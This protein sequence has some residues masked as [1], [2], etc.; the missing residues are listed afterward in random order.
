MNKFIFAAITIYFSIGI[1]QLIIGQQTT[2]KLDGV[3]KSNLPASFD[4]QNYNPEDFYYDRFGNKDLISNIKINRRADRTAINRSG[5]AV[6]AGYFELIYDETNTGFNE[7][8]TIGAK[9]RAVLE[10]VL[11]DIS[12]LLSPPPVSDPCTGALSNVILLIN[13]NTTFDQGTL[14]AA[15]SFYYDN[16][17]NSSIIDGEVWTRL[18]HGGM[19]YNGFADGKINI[20]FDI[21]YYLELD[22]NQNPINILQFDL[23]SV[24]LHEVLHA[25]GFNSSIDENGESLFDYRDLFSRFDQL[26]THNGNPVLS[27]WSGLK[28]FDL[29][30]NLDQYSVADGCQS[31]RSVPSSCNYKTTHHPIYSPNIYVEGS[32]LSHFDAAC[33]DGDGNYRDY[34]MSPSLDPGVIRRFPDIEEVY[35]LNEIGY[36]TTGIYGENSSLASNYKNYNIGET[37]TAIGGTD[38]GYECSVEYIVRTCDSHSILIPALENDLNNPDGYLEIDPSYFG[39]HVVT[40]NIIEF[41]PANDVYRSINLNYVP[42][43]GCMAGSPTKIKIMLA[44]CID[45]TCDLINEN[46]SLCA[47]NCNG[48]LENY[49]FG[50]IHGAESE[51]NDCN[52]YKFYRDIVQYSVPHWTKLYSSCDIVK[53]NVTGNSSIYAA[54]GEYPAY[55]FDF[56]AG[57]LY[58]FKFDITP[59]C[60]TGLNYTPHTSKIKIVLYNE[61]GDGSYPQNF[62]FGSNSFQ[63]IEQYMD[64][65]SHQDVL[66]V[67]SNIG[68]S[69]LTVDSIST[70]LS[71][72]NANENYNRMGLYYDSEDSTI[73]RP[74]NRYLIDNLLIHQIQEDLV[75]DKIFYACATEQYDIN[76]CA[77]FQTDQ[78]E[79]LDEV[80]SQIIGYGNNISIKEPGN[81]SFVM[82]DYDNNVCYVD[83]FNVILD[84]NYF[85]V[86]GEVRDIICESNGSIKL[87]LSGNDTTNLIFVWSHGAS[88]KNVIITN[89]GIYTVDVYNDTSC[90]RTLSFEINQTPN[91][92]EIDFTVTNPD[93]Y[94]DGVI[95]TNITNYDTTNST[96]TYL[97]EDNSTNDYLNVNTS[98]NYLVKITNENG[99][100]VSDSVD[101]TLEFDTTVTV[102]IEGDNGPFCLPFETTLETQ[103]TGFNDGNYQWFLNGTIINNATGSIYNA[104]QSGEYTVMYTSLNCE[105]LSNEF[106]LQAGS[107]CTADKPLNPLPN[108]QEVPL[109]GV[110]HTIGGTIPL[111]PL[112]TYYINGPLTIRSNTIISAKEIVFGKFGEIIVEDDYEL[113]IKNTLGIG[114]TIYSAS[115]PSHLYACNDMW[116]GI[117]LDGPNANL[118][119][120]P[121]VIIEDAITAVKA[122]NGAGVTA[123]SVLFN[124][125]Y[126]GV[127]LTNY[128]LDILNYP[129]GIN[130]SI[131]SCHELDFD[132]IFI[133]SRAIPGSTINPVDINI[134]LTGNKYA[135]TTL[136][137]PYGNDY[138]QIGI[139]PEN[140][141]TANTLSIANYWDD[142][143]NP[144]LS[145]E[146]NSNL[147]I[148]HH[149]GIQSF[150]AAIT[151]SNSDFKDIDDA[152]KTKNTW[153]NLRIFKNNITDF[154]NSGIEVF[155]FVDFTQQYLQARQI[156]QNTMSNFV[157]RGTGIVMDSDVNTNRTFNGGF[158]YV[159]NVIDLN[160]ITGTVVG[161]DLKKTY[162]QNF[163]TRNTIDCKN[164]N[165]P[166][167]KGINLSYSFCHMT[168]NNFSNSYYGVI[169]N[170]GYTGKFDCNTYTN[171]EFGVQD[172]F[173]ANIGSSHNFS[174][175]HSTFNNCLID[176]YLPN[177]VGNHEQTDESANAINLYAPNANIEIIEREP[178]TCYSPGYI[179][180]PPSIN[181]STS[182]SEA[183]KNNHLISIY[184]NPNHGTFTI[185]HSLQFDNSG[186]QVS[187]YTLVGEKILTTTIHANKTELQLIG[188][189]AGVYHVQFHS[190]KSNEIANSK[191]IIE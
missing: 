41:T 49:S 24:I 13:D 3:Y 166:L 95:Q 156:I 60:Y 97:W 109:E 75:Q 141:T 83:P 168:L 142:V 93:C 111:I 157:S 26:L 79:W 155:E 73:Y 151:I 181:V 71:C 61:L 146:F 172:N 145:I 53:D 34:V 131:F 43:Y 126:I 165:N 120:E 128:D 7:S 175:Q 167:S 134:D 144:I 104:T 102:E 36:K 176:Y 90:V 21:N 78:Y 58:Q 80:T 101:V 35:L 2:I 173:I 68:E 108:I 191:L 22:T 39:I 121:L 91:E 54:S 100:L 147:F 158:T 87:I 92:F 149:M 69:I 103:V 185:Q 15:S 77:D 62:D 18:I 164:R 159:N 114:N 52:G 23:Y 94:Q 122:S 50:R 112:V 116:K 106:N 14:G 127:S 138:S 125:N 180:T 20:N 161:I 27:S 57:K 96:Y 89:P 42:N 10:Q 19:P 105:F 16:N 133:N 25:L 74:A 70:F 190:M 56:V 182:I 46:D 85:D 32:S 84:N 163:V 17:A 37:G 107:C 76:I 137:A 136:K 123:E 33:T 179:P 129:V 8:G 183:V 115:I 44:P 150:Q 9:R 55:K 119:I 177:L 66:Y 124:K 117:K 153:N 99:C 29:Y 187:V 160:K 86:S 82:K 72:F 188:L 132:K 31:I 118:V 110:V 130:N 28:F 174:I 186:V 65:R 64:E 47:Q 184:P 143:V 88:D 63:I 81:Y 4:D 170:Y 1:N 178:T 45:E 135:P 171:H 139:Q 12:V 30:S 48:D 148:H 67:T 6:T 169:S 59:Y 113:I 140:I 51:I 98:D 152:I 38:D 40:N 11:K 154:R 162:T 5:S 189:P